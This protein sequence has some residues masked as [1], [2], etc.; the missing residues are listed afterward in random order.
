MFTLP[1]GE[2]FAM[3]GTTD[4]RT[5]E[6]PAEV[7]ATTGD[8]DYLLAAANHY[9]PAARLTRAD[10]VSAWA[11]IRP[12]A[13]GG[14][15][16]R[17]GG[18]A[19]A[20]SASREH[21]ITT[22]PSGVVSITGGKLTTYRVMAAEV[23]D[24]VQAALGAARTSARAAGLPGG[25]LAS[26]EAEC[27][28]ATRATGDAAV[29]ARL[30]RALGSRWRDAWALADADPALAARVVPTL[31]YTLAE[32]RWAMREE[33]AATLADLLV[34]RTHVAFEVPDAGRAVARAIAPVLGFDATAVAEYERD[35]ARLFAITS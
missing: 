17:A 27:A 21:A 20:A 34:R 33:E 25:D 8:V 31:P 4:T 1:A 26:I 35:A 16:D 2:A 24:T 5:D 9:F 18:G 10:V 7:R 32:L 13:A 6:H 29:G 14:W 30:V 11:G 22:S 3:I 23:V 28:A 15:S 12:L 19:S